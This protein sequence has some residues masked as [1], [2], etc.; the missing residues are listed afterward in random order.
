MKLYACQHCRQLLFF[1]NTKC[2]NCGHTL[3]YLPDLGVLSALEEVEGGWRALAGG[4]PAYRFCANAE[5]QA[6]NWLV[7]ASSSAALCRACEHNRTIPD[8]ANQEHLARWR[9][10]EF[11]KHRLIYTLK[12]LDL[13]LVSKAEDPEKGFA[14]AFMADPETPDENRAKVLTGHDNGLITI[15]IAEADDA[16]RERRRNALHEPSRTLL[17]HVRHEVGHYYWDRLIAGTDRLGPFRALF[18]DERADYGAALQAHYQNGPPADWQNRFVTA[19]AAAHPWEDWAE[20][21]AHYLHMTDTLE[22]AAA[23]GVSIKPRRRDEPALPRVP[24]AA[25]SPDAAFDRLM[26]SWFPLTYV[27]NNL[28][29]GLGQADAYPFVLSTPAIEKLRFVH[30][31]VAAGAP[32]RPAG[33]PADSA[34]SPVSASGAASS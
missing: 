6:C 30:D 13:P 21:W 19:Y 11:A 3:G 16:E 5:H 15:N 12:N 23:C 9:K 32:G 10:L 18:G 31:V 33:T 29:R 25:G 24:A 8:V 7:P 20:T 22:T 34:V 28:N 2:E 4:E 27:L 1:E 17:G 26:A 14:F